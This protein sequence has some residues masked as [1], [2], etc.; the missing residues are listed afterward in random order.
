MPESKKRKKQPRRQRP[1]AQRTVSVDADKLSATVDLISAATGGAMASVHL[2]AAGTNFV[3][4]VAVGDLAR[5]S[6][7]TS[8]VTALISLAQEVVGNTPCSCGEP[9]SLGSSSLT[10]VCTWRLRKIQ[11]EW[12]DWVGECG[13]THR[14]VAWQ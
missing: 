7:D 13:A 4:S 9:I 2:D 6:T 12:I 10:E 11:S 5:T 1:T 14:M 8:P 3:A